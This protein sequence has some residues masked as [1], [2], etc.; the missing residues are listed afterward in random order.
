MSI[1]FDKFSILLK[2][3]S[4]RLCDKH[5]AERGHERFMTSSADIDCYTLFFRLTIITDIVTVSF[6]VR[7]LKIKSLT[8][9]R[10]KHIPA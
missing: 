9:N 3:G 8:R 5:T 10:N 1:T 6:K 7:C 2:K 4:C